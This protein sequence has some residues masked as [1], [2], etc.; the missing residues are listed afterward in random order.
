MA[1][2]HDQ[3]L[4]ADELHRRRRRYRPT[5]QEAMPR[6]TLIFRPTPDEL[7]LHGD[8]GGYFEALS[9][10]RRALEEPTLMAS[11]RRVLSS[12]QAHA[13]SDE[14]V[15]ER[16]ARAVAGGRMIVY[17]RPPPGRPVGV[18]YTAARAPDYRRLLAGP[19]VGLVPHPWLGLRGVTVGIGKRLATPVAALGIRFVHRGGIR[20]AT[21]AEIMAGCATVSAAIAG[22]AAIAYRDLTDLDLA[23]AEAE[24]L[25]SQDLESAEDSCR[26]LFGG[27][28]RFPLPAQLALLDVIY[29]LGDGL[30]AALADQTHGQREDGL[31]QF[32]RLREAVAKEDWVAASR[33]CRRPDV[34]AARDLWTRDK[35]IEAAHLAP[36]RPD[37][38][39]AVRL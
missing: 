24:R 30:A 17:S 28:E 4:P 32:R 1:Q 13:L 2:T 8:S 34:A 26:G 10:L 6:P 7:R 29:D 39:R 37:P 18:R 11:L 16:L 22:Q 36:A 3:D 23:P 21:A 19:F 38:H 20:L 25:L 5:L 35:F 31:Y 14:A 12:T 9:V 27:W 15:L 33:D